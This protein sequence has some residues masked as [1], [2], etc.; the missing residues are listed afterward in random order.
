MTSQRQWDVHS[1]LGGQQPRRIL[2][3][4]ILIE[5]LPTGRETLQ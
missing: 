2:K 1:L 3:D 4:M 5:L